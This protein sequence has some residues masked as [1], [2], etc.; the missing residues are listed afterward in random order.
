MLKNFTI[1][2]IGLVGY[3]CYPQQTELKLNQQKSYITLNGS[4]TFNNW[5]S[6][7]KSFKGIF[8]FIG[9]NKLSS[10][11]RGSAVIK[12]K[13]DSIVSRNRLR[14]KTTHKALKSKEFPFI[15]FTSN[16]GKLYKRITDK[17][18]QLTITGILNIADVSRT[19]TLLANLTELSKNS[20]EFE[21]HY[22]LKMTDYGIKPPSVLFGLIKAKGEININ[23]YLVFSN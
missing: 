10:S 18:R 15:Q 4:S 5:K 19:I 13:I 12:I 14:D 17:K 3:I 20:L 16:S 11:K 21:G 2:L 7:A 6:E 1:V 22:T 23:Y 8:N 9:N